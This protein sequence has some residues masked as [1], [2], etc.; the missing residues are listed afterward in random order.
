MITVNGL[1]GDGYLID[2]PIEVELISNN[3]N[4]YFWEISFENYQ[5]GKIISGIII[6]PNQTENSKLNIASV[7]KGLFTLPKHE[8]NY[9]ATT[10]INIPN[11]SNKVGI[12]INS[13]F[14]DGTSESTYVEKTFIR[15]GYYGTYDTLTN[16]MIPTGTILENAEKVPYFPGYP[17]AVYYLNAEK[18][19]QKKNIFMFLYSAPEIE[20]MRVKSCGGGHIK[21]LNS[22][23]GYSYWLFENWKETTENDNLGISNS[24][25]PII[26]Y[27]NELDFTYETMSKVPIR[28]AGLMTDLIASKEIYLWLNNGSFKMGGTSQWKRISIKSSNK[29]E[30]KRTSKIIDVQIKFGQIK[31]YNP[32]L[33]WSN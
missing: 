32:S 17:C 29:I 21:F 31:N 4:L 6:Y 9:I 28:Y 2:N 14:M 13:V 18:K 15:G 27:G 23:G 26:D 12:S 19:V 5:N 25:N 30:T 1:Q 3:E 10:E 24:L 7:I 33:L 8:G 16:R 22:L 20:R 11:N